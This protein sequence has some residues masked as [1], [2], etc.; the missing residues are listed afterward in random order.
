MYT[1]IDNDDKNV[2]IAKV[3]IYFNGV[4]YAT[5]AHSFGCV[6]LPLHADKEKAKRP[7]IAKWP[8]TTLDNCLEYFAGRYNSRKQGVGVLLGPASGNLVVVDI[9]DAQSWEEF[10]EAAERNDV[11]ALLKDKCAVV[12]TGGG[13]AHVYMRLSDH[14]M[15]TVE[16]GKVLAS[17]MR[18]PPRTTHALKADGS[19]VRAE[20]LGAGKQAVRHTYAHRYVL[21]GA[22]E[23]YHTVVLEHDEYISLLSCAEQLGDVLTIVQ[24]HAAKQQK[25]QQ[26]ELNNKDPKAFDCIK[27][28]NDDVSI[29]FDEILLR[30]KWT[31]SHASNK[32]GER[33][34]TRP[35]K[36]V[37]DGHSAGIIKKEGYNK[38]VLYMHSDGDSALPKTAKG[39]DKWALYVA[40]DHGGN[41]K[42]ARDAYKRRLG[43]E[44]S[45]NKKKHKKI[46]KIIQEVGGVE[47]PDSTDTSIAEYYI[48]NTFCSGETVVSTGAGLYV[49]D[50]EKGIY[51]HVPTMV[52]Q[53]DIRAL[54]RKLYAPNDRGTIVV[55]KINKTRTDSV[56]HRVLVDK[57]M[58]DVDFLCAAK[59]GEETYTA[60]KNTTLVCNIKKQTIEYVEHS[61]SY[62]LISAYD[63]DVSGIDDF[64]AQSDCPRFYR[65]LHEV[66][67]DDA[68]KNA[69]IMVLQ[70]FFG[71]CLLNIAT[72]YQKMLGLVGNGANGKSVLLKTIRE[73]LFGGCAISSV[74]LQKFHYARSLHALV[75]ARIN[76]V[77]ELP[78]MEL[79][80]SSAVKSIIDGDIATAEQKY[81]NEFLFTPTAGHVFAV[82]N[83]PVTADN[84]HGFWRR[85][86]IIEFPNTFTGGNAVAGLELD[87]IR[88]R[89]GIAA[90][91]LVGAHRLIKTGAYTQ[92]QASE[93]EEQ[94]KMQ[95]DSVYAFF[96]E[97]LIAS[98]SC[99]N[100]AAKIYS[101]YKSYCEDTGRK[102]VSSISMGI[103]LKQ[104]GVKGRHTRYGKVWCCAFEP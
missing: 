97:R 83:L 72:H 88:E 77:T 95:S 38:E 41:A 96:T 43:I 11:D 67:A 32:T 47:L 100:T 10:K 37:K 51:N 6:C 70:E 76:I 89:S 15:A 99:E 29:T 103:R 92:L 16:N 31:F 53:S 2:R 26:L 82:N 9:E 81:V 24:N 57:K 8:E 58:L 23:P 20:L 101:V 19:Y 46:A 61:P 79:A 25:K 56:M 14:D 62:K 12:R 90:W 21:E 52:I 36:D 33:F 63:Y 65:Y 5:A 55:V 50:V 66:F 104:F 74:P 102:P 34:W 68:Q 64:D 39:Y 80:E 30:H 49:Y 75:G 1:D 22:R 44:E 3:D 69:K 98:E 42:S 91:A 93:T 78:S 73:G 27:T 71:A 35:N 60:F 84:S 85:L 13:G 17:T 40:L 54:E 28:F 48:N 7:C 45:E 4:E 59:N 86:I 18:T 87:L 94:C